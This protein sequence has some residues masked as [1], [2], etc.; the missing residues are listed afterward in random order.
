MKLVPESMYRKILA[1]NSDKEEDVNLEEKLK[2]DKSQ[3]FRDASLADDVKLLLL[4]N[5]NRQLIDRKKEQENIPIL[6]QSIASTG[7]QQIQPPILKVPTQKLSALSEQV[8]RNLLNGTTKRGAEILNFMRKNGAIVH[9]DKVELDNVTYSID[10]MNQYLVTLCNGLNAKNKKDALLIGLLKFFKDRN[11]PSDLFPNTVN[12]YLR[13]QTGG[14]K[15]LKISRN[16]HRRHIKLLCKK[17]RKLTIK[18]WEK[19]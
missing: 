9:E 3:L 7:Q 5:I 14:R 10:V 1:L 2:D 4:Q 6:T 19:F 13:K 8:L 11:A 18:D 17:M 15:A 16:R 12:S